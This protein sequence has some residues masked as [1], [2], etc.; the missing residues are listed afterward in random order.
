MRESSKSG[1]G[2]VE[3]SDVGQ[4]K[5]LL[6]LEAGR[7]EAAVFELSRAQPAR[8]FGV[9]VIL[10]ASLGFGNRGPAT[11]ARAAETSGSCQ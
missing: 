11:P 9:Q 8:R 10:R 1:C 6:S 7:N 4:S 3:Q 5:W 2:A